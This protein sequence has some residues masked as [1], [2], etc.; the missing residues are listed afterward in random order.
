MIKPSATEFKRLV[1]L[2]DGESIQFE[3]AMSE[4][5]FLNEVYKNQWGNIGFRNN[6]NLAAYTQQR[7]FW[8]EKEAAGLN[9]IHYTMESLVGVDL[10][11][12]RY[13][14]CGTKKRKRIQQHHPQWRNMKQAPAPVD[15][16]IHFGSAQAPGNASSR[17]LNLKSDYAVRVCGLA[18][19]TPHCSAPPELRRRPLVP[20][21]DLHRLGPPG[22]WV[23]V[24][25]EMCSGLGN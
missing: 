16:H 22:G 11:M 3:T 9:V 12:P 1:E 14:A 23:Q 10:N 15:L 8:D 19:P 13:A 25:W 21:S 6:A 2:K 18:E 17:R 24:C 20:A 5:G 4:Q 7:N